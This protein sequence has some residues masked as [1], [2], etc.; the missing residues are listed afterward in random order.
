MVGRRS[1][2]VEAGGELPAVPDHPTGSRIS[3]C[4]DFH[5]DPSGSFCS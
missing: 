4:A 5:L 2:V 3:P 1:W